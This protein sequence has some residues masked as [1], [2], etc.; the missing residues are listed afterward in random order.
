MR[1]FLNCYF[2]SFTSYIRLFMRADVKHTFISNKGIRASAES[3]LKLVRN[4]RQYVYASITI[5]STKR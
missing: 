1:T 4:K 2:Y 5:S 3:S